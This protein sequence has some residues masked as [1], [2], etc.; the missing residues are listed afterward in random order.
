MK[1]FIFNVII[2]SLFFS[3]YNNEQDAK[4]D[5][6]SPYIGE[7]D[8]TDLQSN[9]AL[10]INNDGVAS[11]NFFNQFEDFYYYLN[12]S[13]SSSLS[14]KHIDINSKENIFT[15]IHPV[16]N[17]HFSEP[18][19]YNSYLESVFN[20]TVIFNHEFSSILEFY[21]LFFN[22]ETNKVERATDEYLNYHKW[23]IIREINF[24]ENNT[25]KIKFN[26]KFFT[27]NTDWVVC[28][29]Q[30]TYEKR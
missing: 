2:L 15:I 11:H 5:I 30:A 4:Q 23:P 29:L 1:V 14:I 26:Q 20:W 13:N 10:D 28:E 25:V 3:C 16:Q 24:L 9:I 19:N 6:I 7:Y 22:S 18:E 8:I 12:L 17:F 21:Y 27:P